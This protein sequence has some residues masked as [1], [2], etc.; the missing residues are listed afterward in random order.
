LIHMYYLVIISFWSC[1][2]YIET[3]SSY[4]S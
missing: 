1:I 3:V 2:E 4:I